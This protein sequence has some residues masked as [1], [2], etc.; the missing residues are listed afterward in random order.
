MPPTPV[1]SRR[2]VLGASLAIGGGAALAGC[3]RAGTTGG[4]G[5]GKV[6][7]P[8]WTHSAGNEGELSV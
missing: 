6:Q 2:T 3:A 8:M 1:L 5:A 4:S 7:I